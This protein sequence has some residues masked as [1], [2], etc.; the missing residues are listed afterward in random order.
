MKTALINLLVAILASPAYSYGW[1]IRSHSHSKLANPSKYSPTTLFA[2][3]GSEEKHAVADPTKA[4]KQA[5]ET[6]KK[7]GATSYK[8]RM[9]WEVVETIEH[10]SSDDSKNAE[11]VEVAENTTSMKN[12]TRIIADVATYDLVENDVRDLKCLIDA[13]LAKLNDMKRIASKIK[14]MKKE[15]KTIHKSK[16]IEAIAAAQEATREY[17]IHSSQTAL[18]WEAFEE[19]VSSGLAP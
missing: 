7:Y 8:A 15:Y 14:E 13:E 17:G 16:S 12:E 5:I 6:T 3:S 10:S 1:C 18:A 19:T 11:N 4:I 9:A 2:S